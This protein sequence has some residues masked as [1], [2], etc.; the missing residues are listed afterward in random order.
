MEA[1]ALAQVAQA[2]Q[3]L[4]AALVGAGASAHRVA[5]VVWVRPAGLEESAERRGAAASEPVR[6]ILPA[7]DS[8]PARATARAAP[9]TS[10]ARAAR[11][12]SCS[13]ATAWATGRWAF[14]RRAIS[15]T[16][17][18]PA[19][20]STVSRILAGTC[21]KERIPPP[22]VPT[23]LR[24]AGRRVSQVPSGVFGNTVAIRAYRRVG[25]SPTAHTIPT[26]LN[27]FGR[28]ALASEV[29]IDRKAVLWT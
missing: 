25:W 19:R 16:T 21:R 10:S 15:P 26:A 14:M 27:R 7:A 5:A 13:S 29:C 8:S 12:A 3:E 22:H 4:P 17:P 23:R 1:G 24:A 28:S 20:A 2:R 9:T 18:V 11:R 6:A